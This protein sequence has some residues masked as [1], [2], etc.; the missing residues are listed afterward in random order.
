[1]SVYLKNKLINHFVLLEI[2]QMSAGESA[3]YHLLDLLLIYL[4]YIVTNLWR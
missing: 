2:I 4:I 3:T 1:M